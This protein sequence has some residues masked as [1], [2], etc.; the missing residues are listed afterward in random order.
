MR[1][2]KFRAFDK[3]SKKMIYS[4]ERDMK[5]RDVEYSFEVVE[6]VVQ[7][8]W[9]EDCYDSC[10][11]PT[12]NSELLDNIMQYTGLKDK[13]GT[14]IYEGDIVKFEDVGEEGYEYKEGFDFTNYASVVFEGGRWELN[15]FLDNNS[16]MLE[17]M[18]SSHEDFIA[19]FGTFEVIGNIH[20][21]SE[22]LEGRK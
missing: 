15:N 14:E 12:V 7:C 21:N 6:D 16:G 2:I 5:E 11:Y 22:L 9:E 10:G 17:T 13:N 18:N 20:E 1:E 8:W 4:D 19:E 3:V